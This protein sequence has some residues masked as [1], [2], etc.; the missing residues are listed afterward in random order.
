MAEIPQTHD[1]PLNHSDY[2]EDD[3]VAPETPFPEQ[4][5][6]ETAIDA[7]PKVL[8]EAEPK[9]SNKLKIAIGVAATGAVSA[10]FTAAAVFGVGATREAPQTTTPTIS[11]EQ[12][13]GTTTASAPNTAD[14][15]GASPEHSVTERIRVDGKDYSLNEARQQLFTVSLS[16]T[17]TFEEAANKYLKAVQTAMNMNTDRGTISDAGNSKK[18]V[19]DM[20]M[21]LLTGDDSVMLGLGAKLNKVNSS[22]QGKRL[23]PGTLAYHKGVENIEKETISELVSLPGTRKITGNEAAGYM[24][25]ETGFVTDKQQGSG[26]AL[27]S[28]QYEVEIHGKADHATGKWDFSDSVFVPFGKR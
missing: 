4:Q 11:G 28:D 17:P 26:A 5:N 6:H 20:N 22:G 7:Y 10:V 1:K 18:A 15:Y 21:D 19:A 23:E 16:D 8:H 27:D 2:R 14:T 9:K 24:L 25:R 13:P 3:I 12:V